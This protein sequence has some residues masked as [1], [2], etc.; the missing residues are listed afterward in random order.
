[1]KV[2]F[3]F[4][5]QPRDVKNSLENIKKAWGTYQELDFFFHTWIPEDRSPY[6]IDTPSD[7]YFDGIESHLIEN[8]N[9]VKCE[10]Q[11]Q[12]IFKNQYRDS[13][14]WPIRSTFIPNPS[15]NIQSFFYSL[16]KAN[17]LKCQHEIE[18]NFRYD[19]VI[20][21]RFDYIFTKRYNI[22]DFDLNYLNVKGDCKHTEYAINDHV[23]LSNSKNMDLYSTVI[24][25]MQKYYME[26]IEFNTE[27]ILG[28]NAMVQGLKYH[29]TLGDNDESYVSTKIERNKVFL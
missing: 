25:N 27:V 17:D 5:G 11:R 21:C 9:P 22:K 13:V 20:R 3:C 16:K 23:A 4:C 19:C 15:Q 1:M 10:F 6:R 7:F 2:A 12:I 14:H 24:D 28:Y 8:L 29:K 26:G 18:N